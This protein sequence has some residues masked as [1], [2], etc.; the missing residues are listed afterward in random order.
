LWNTTCTNCELEALAYFI[1]SP[2]SEIGWSG[3][4]G[5]FSCTGRNNY[6]I[7]DHSGTFIPNGGILLANN[8]VIGDNTLGCTFISAINGHHCIRRDFAV[9][10]YENI[11]PDYNTRI[12]WPVSLKF[13]GANFTTLTNGYKEWDWIGN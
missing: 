3:G 8:S 7:E 13:D 2:A 9:L 11:A 10:E 12:M 4:C 6:F 5:N 1:P